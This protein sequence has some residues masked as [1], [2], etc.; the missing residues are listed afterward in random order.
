MLVAPSLI[1]RRPSPV[2]EVVLVAAGPD[3]SVDAG[4]AAEGLAGG[5][6]DRAVV[7]AR[8][9]LGAE[10]P[11][12]LAA[13]I[14]EPSLGDQDARPQILAACL[15]QQDKRIAIF[16][17][18]PRHDRAGGTGTDDDIIVAGLESRTERGLIGLDRDEFVGS[19]GNG[20][21]RQTE[22]RGARHE[23]RTVD[24]VGK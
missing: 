22:A 23:G 12:K 14:E 3:H 1:A 10:A 21:G 18:A 6:G 5:L 7:D 19:L 17:E 2:I 4:A 16:G 11:V 13:L 20:C 9:A 15:Q 8:A 24:F